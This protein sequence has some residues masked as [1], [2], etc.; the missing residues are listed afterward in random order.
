MGT[1]DQADETLLRRWVEGRDRDAAD[2]LIRRHE[3]ALYAF[4]LRLS[5]S[6][7]EASDAVQESFLRLL[8][9]A[10]KFRGG[11]AV[12]TWLFGIAVNVVRSRRFRLRRLRNLFRP[13]EAMESQMA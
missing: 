8:Q 9:R 3:T 7:T 10:E 2:R 6:E 13:L 5:R 1:Q 12:R 4:C 11:S